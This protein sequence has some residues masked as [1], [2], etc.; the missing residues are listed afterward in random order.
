MADG[1]AG[2]LLDQTMPPLSASTQTRARSV[3]SAAAVC[4]NRR[5]PQTIGDEWP[6]PGMLIFQR[7]FSLSLHWTGTSLSAAV[8]VPLGPRNRDHSAAPAARPKLN[9]T[10]Q[11]SS[12]RGRCMAGVLSSHNGRVTGRLRQVVILSCWTAGGCNVFSEF[13]MP[14]SAGTVWIAARYQPRSQTV[15]LFE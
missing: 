11:T 7:M 9:R 6:L 14:L 10:L 8:P 4:R 2:T 13:L 12:K 3:P 5:L 15:S 1:W